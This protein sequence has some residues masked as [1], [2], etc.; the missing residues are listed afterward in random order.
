MSLSSTSGDSPVQPP[1]KRRVKGNRLLMTVSSSIF[2]ISGG[3]STI[4]PGNSVQCWITCSKTV[5]YLNFLNGISC[6]WVCAFCLFSFQWVA[7][8]GV[9]LLYTL[10]LHTLVR[11]SPWASSS[12]GPAVP[13]LSASPCMAA[14]SVPQS[15]S[16]P[17]TGLSMKIFYSNT[18]CLCIFIILIL[19]IF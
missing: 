3:N 16:C 18:H 14:A 13:P 4:S 19:H 1:A 9:C 11:F 15:S 10:P 2:N 17:L 6:V 8:R 7:V 12:P 5:F